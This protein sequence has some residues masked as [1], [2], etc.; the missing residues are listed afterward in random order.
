[1]SA[2]SLEKHCYKSLCWK[3]YQNVGT[4]ACVASTAFVRLFKEFGHDV[5]VKMLRLISPV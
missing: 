5:L 4:E 1:M 3:A 2:E